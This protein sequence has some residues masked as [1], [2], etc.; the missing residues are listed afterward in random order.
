MLNDRELATAILLGVVIAACCLSKDVRS[1]FGLRSA[2]GWKLPL[3]GLTYVLVLAGSVAGLH[4]I[5]LN[6]PGST[7]DAVVWGLLVGLPL[8][9]G[10]NSLGQRPGSE[11]A[12]LG[13]IVSLTVLVEFF[14]NL[15]VFPLWVELML[16]PFV[17]VVAWM[18]VVAA[19]D[20]R[21]RPAVW[22]LDVILALSGIVMIVV[23]AWYLLRHYQEIDPRST[24]LSFLQPVLLSLAIIL[25]TYIVA[26]VSS[27][28]S[29]FLRIGWHQPSR[30][31]RLRAKF[32]LATTLHVRL[33][34]VHNFAGLLPQRLADT[35]SWRSAR[36]FV[37]TYRSGDLSQLDDA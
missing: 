23:V 12:M 15:Y 24:A 37:R 34:K 16:Q 1:S 13:R 25:L 9:G 29:A 5:G 28:E 31:Q 27:Y 10:F 2:F 21:Y 11:R 33:H 6:Y 3:I 35:G 19:G 20:N 32:A 18:S 26:L 36:Q 22:L 30:R 4:K 17:A 7:K 8:L 14:V